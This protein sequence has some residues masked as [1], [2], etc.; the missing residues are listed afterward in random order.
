MT[1]ST[2]PEIPEAT[3]ILFSPS[4]PATMDGQPKAVS[5]LTSVRS[6]GKE[7]LKMAVDESVAWILPPR[8][9]LR[10]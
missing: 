7:D 5:S 2:S 3:Q 8:W 9:Q 10:Y 1:E 4:A 6:P